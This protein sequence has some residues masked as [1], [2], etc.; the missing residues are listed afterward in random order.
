MAGPHLTVAARLYLLIAPALLAGIL[1][2]E[3]GP[4]G[5]T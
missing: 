4:P 1:A 3:P 2:G 5:L